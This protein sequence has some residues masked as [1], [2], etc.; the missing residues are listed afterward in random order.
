GNTKWGEYF[1][2]VIDEV[3]V[4]NR[5]QTAAQI[6]TDMNAPVVSVTA[7]K[8]MTKAQAA[9]AADDNNPQPPPAI[10]EYGRMTPDD[11]KRNF[12]R[13]NQPEGYARNHYSWC[14]TSHLDLDHMANRASPAM[15]FSAKIVIMA[16]T[17]NG[18]NSVERNNGGTSRDVFVDVHLYE[19]T[20]TGAAFGRN[21][22]IGVEP[23]GSGCEHVTSWGGSPTLNYR[24]KHMG[25]WANFGSARFR[26]R[27]PASKAPELR[28]IKWSPS[29]S[30]TV[31][32]LEDVSVGGFKVYGYSPDWPAPQGGYGYANSR[33]A[34]EGATIV[35]CD[36]ASYIVSQ[37]GCVFN[38]ATPMMIWKMGQGY[39]SA[40]QHYWKACYQPIDTF[41][42]NLHKKLLGCHRPGDMKDNYLHRED[43]EAAESA[44]SR[45]WRTCR[46]IW[47][48]YAPSGKECDEYPFA[49]SFERSNAA[50]NNYSLCPIPAAENNLAGNLLEKRFFIKDRVIV[51]DNYYNKFTTRIDVPPTKEA[52]CG[53]PVP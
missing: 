31:N 50:T 51:G 30:E 29:F 45:T 10:Y 16:Y 26:L 52:L 25:I 21:L 47:G 22:T 37:G 35:K 14:S 18:L 40:Y 11:C 3:R 38:S 32:N 41:P 5:A 28:H 24:T 49:S 36:S 23:V 27:C 1:A 12:S 4:Y 39:N 53:A 34:N 2:G 13:S 17:F 46:R 15:S 9:M 20:G 42:I 33:G 6:Q 43:S 48:N 44:H 8:A 19:V 7:R